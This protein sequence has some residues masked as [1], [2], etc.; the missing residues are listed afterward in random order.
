MFSRFHPAFVAFAGSIL[1][2]AGLIAALYWDPFA[3]EDAGS[4]EPLLVYCAEALRVPMEATAKDYQR[5]IGQ[6]V[7]LDFGPSQAL[8]AKLLLTKKGDLF[9]PAD[10]SYI[11]LAREQ[12]CVDSVL[13]L[14]RMSAVVILR[15]GYSGPMDTWADFIAKGHSIGLANADAAAIGKLVRQRLKAL[16]LWGDLDKRQPTFLMNVNDVANTVQIGRLDVGVVWD[17]V[18][19]LHEKKGVKAVHLP[20]FDSVTAKVQVAVTKFSTQ[21][22]AALRFI[23]YLRGKTKGARYFKQQGYTDFVEEEYA[24]RPELVVYAG[25]MLRPAIEETI[26]EFEKKHAVRVTRVYNG[27]GLLV[28]QMRGGQWPDLYFACDPRFMEM[29]EDHFNAAKPISSNQLVI[30]VRKGNP[31]GIQSLSDLGKSGVRIGVGHE[32]QC[33]LGAITK[34]TL[35]RVGVYGPVQKNVVTVSP[36]GDFLVN[37]LR[38]GAKANSPALDT[39]IAY[40]SNVVP[41]ADELEAIPVTGIPCAAPEQ[42][43]AV[44]KSASNA[45]LCRQLQKA[46]E[47]PESKARFEKLGFKWQTDVRGP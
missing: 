19:K 18:A 1:L 38:S 32:Q 24:E 42:P 12:D 2:L 6:Q 43:I 47:S 46:L 40:R 13:P 14:A 34:E 20:E 37:Q 33:A 10:D 15:P 9:L 7:Y 25:A 36:T 22:E 44:S 17:A 26:T 3:S 11:E 5:E 4:S 39:V 23:R 27:C 8:L 30:A 29:V 21:P 16:G 41:F 45:E 35:V 28:S 31:L